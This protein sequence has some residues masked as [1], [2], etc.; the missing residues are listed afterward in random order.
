MPLQLP[1]VHGKERITFNGKFSHM[2]TLPGAGFG[3]LS[4]RRN[5]IGHQDDASQPYELCQRSHRLKVAVMDGI[6]RAAKKCGQ[7]WCSGWPIQM[8][9]SGKA[10]PH[11]SMA[12]D[13]S[14]DQTD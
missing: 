11:S 5:I 1:I 10:L 9:A 3:L 7:R 13:S 4:V 12:S 8:N 6:E 2:K 14:S